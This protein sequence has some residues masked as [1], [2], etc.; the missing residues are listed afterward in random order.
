[1]GSSTKGSGVWLQWVWSVTGVKTP[2]LVVLAGL[3]VNPNS[4]WVCSLGTAVD[5]VI[6]GAALHDRSQ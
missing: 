4:L 3:A 2:V 1:M 6:A 5:Q